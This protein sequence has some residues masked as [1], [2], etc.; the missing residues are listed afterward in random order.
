[1]SVAANP[2]AAARHLTARLF[3]KCAV[4]SLLAVGLLGLAFAASLALGLVL[5]FLAL[6]ASTLWTGHA[7][8]RHAAVNALQT[9]QLR[10]SALEQRLLFEEN[11]QPLFAFDR[12]TLEILAVSNATVESY[13]YSREEF[14]A[15][16]IDDLHVPED[17]EAVRALLEALG[18]NERSGLHSIRH[19][20]HRHRY[21]DGT[22]IDVE[23][24]GDDA[25][26]GGR[27]C[28]I[29]I[30]LNVTE[31]NRVIT[32]LAVAR[33]E[34]IAASN[35]KSAFLANM[36]HEIRTPMNGVI[37]MTELLADSGLN[38]EQQSYAD[39][40]VRSGE[41]MLSIINDILDISKI[42]TGQLEL[43]LTDFALHETIEHQQGGR[44][45]DRVHRRRTA[46]SPRRRR[47]AEPDRP[48]P[49]RQRR[50][51]HRRRRRDGPRRRPAKR[52]RRHACAGR[53]RGHRNRH[54]SGGAGAAVRALHPSRLLDD[55]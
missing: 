27:D 49:G 47:T 10:A 45:G 3:A 24:T 46:L 20:R 53:G 5:L 6:L 42:E 40:I 36:S 32:E 43:D 17:A 37:G 12:K 52:S 38:E 11:P 55:T 41:R 22:I 26:L 9:E 21:K 50:Q 1:M 35:T 29:A 31:R 34:A 39:H 25:T 33:D 15:M 14:L 28:H 19:T 7:L 2:T 54:R 51:V 4:I 30:C 48:Q 8:R 16:R 13:G 18:H 44:A 23:I